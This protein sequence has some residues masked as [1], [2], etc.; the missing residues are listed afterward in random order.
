MATMR[1]ARLQMAAGVPLRRGGW[2]RV[3]SETPIEVVVSVHG[4]PVPVL[5]PFV[6]IRTTPPRDW[7]VLRHPTVAPGRTPERFRHGYMV[8]PGCRE[9]AVLPPTQRARLRCQRCGQTFPIAWEE[10]YLEE[11]NPPA[12]RRGN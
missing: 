4:R 7:T 6:E 3:V 9:R 11:P 12:R 1:W 2:Y 5:R 8:C 10:H